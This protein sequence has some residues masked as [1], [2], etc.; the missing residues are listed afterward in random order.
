MAIRDPGAYPWVTPLRRAIIGP[1]GWSETEWDERLRA[2]RLPVLAVG[3][4][5]SP[6]VLSDKLADLLEPRAGA[7]YLEV[8]R[9]VGLAVG[10]SAHLSRPGYVAAAPCRTSLPQTDAGARGGAGALETAYS[11]AW[12]TPTQAGALDAT[13]PNYDRL[14][15]PP[16]LTARTIE[17]QVAIQG[18]QLYVSRHGVLA[19]DGRPVPL[20]AQPDAVAWLR[21]RLTCI[22]DV[23]DVDLFADPNIRESVRRELAD[24]GWALPSGLVSTDRESSARR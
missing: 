7:V 10:H 22:R 20:M 21:E 24:G 18:V 9:V 4:N 13:E 8:C 2:D 15:L 5:A 12:L 1:S 14:P 6:A 3:S 19:R 16:D 17:T 11:L 23:S